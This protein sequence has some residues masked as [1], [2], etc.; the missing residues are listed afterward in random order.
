[1][2]GHA[3]NTFFFISA[4]LGCIGLGVITWPTKEKQILRAAADYNYY[5]ILI[6]A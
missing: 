6:I 2:M 1:M 3:H 5:D 4:D